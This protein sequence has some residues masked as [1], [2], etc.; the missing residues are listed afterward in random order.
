MNRP[1]MIVEIDELVLHGF[2][3]RERSRIGDA[4]Q[5]ELQTLLAGTPV[6]GRTPRP[7]DR[8]DAG[9]FQRAGQSSGEVG[10]LTAR[11][12]HRSLF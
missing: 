2:D 3:P 9:H 10:Q 5:A 11:A 8:V 4:V 1:R 6:A 12:V 7:A